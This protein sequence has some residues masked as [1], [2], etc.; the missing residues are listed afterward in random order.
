[1]RWLK[2]NIRNIHSLWGQASRGEAA[3]N[4]R[5]EAVRHAMLAATPDV[6]GQKHLDVFR[7]IRYANNIQTLWYAR[8]E[9]MAA[10]A[11]EKGEALARQE[12]GAIT[13]MFEGLLEEYKTHDQRRPGG[14]K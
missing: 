4:A 14:K 13:K 9:L 10:I 1:M 5:T 6:P 12:I 8:S 2:P 3:T 7:R 11:F